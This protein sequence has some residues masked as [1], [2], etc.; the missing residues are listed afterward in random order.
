MPVEV[1]LSE[2]IAVFRVAGTCKVE[3]IVRA[4]EQHFSATPTLLAL[5]DLTD[6]S[7]ANVA[8]G[9]FRRIIEASDRFA[10]ARGDGARSA[11]VAKGEI[12]LLLTK[13]FEAHASVG[14]RVGIV[15]FD[16]RS[17]AVAW[18]RSSASGGGG[19]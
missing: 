16:G 5:W 12:N 17:A 13:A 9:E 1:E 19:G 10:A 6:A 3:E 8:A 18:L 2:G 15:A 14:T 11:V 7:L 4:I